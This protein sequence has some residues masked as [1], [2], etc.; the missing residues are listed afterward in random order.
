MRDLALLADDDVWKTHIDDDDWVRYIHPA[1]Y[2][3]FTILRAFSGLS[4]FASLCIVLESIADLK[5]ISSSTGNGQSRRRGVNGI[6]ATISRILLTMHS[7]VMI[8]MICFTLGMVMVPKNVPDNHSGGYKAHGNMATCTAQGFLLTLSS[9][10]IAAWDIA[11]C[12]TYILILMHN[13]TAQQ[14][15]HAEPYFFAFAAAISL[16]ISIPPLFNQSYN[17]RWGV[18]TLQSYKPFCHAYPEDP[19]WTCERGEDYIIYSAIHAAFISISALVGLI[20]MCKIYAKVRRLEVATARYDFS[21]TPTRQQRF[22]RRNQSNDTFASQQSPTGASRSTH[23]NRQSK[24]RQF[25]IQA[26]LYSGTAV[27]ASIFMISATV[28]NATAEGGDGYLSLITG[29]TYASYGT[30]YLMIFLRNRSE[31]KTLYGRMIRRLVC[32]VDVRRIFGKLPRSTKRSSSSNK[33][34]SSAG[35][36]S[37][38]VAPQSHRSGEFR[39]SAFHEPANSSR[40]SP[41]VQVQDDSFNDADADDVIPMEATIVMN[42]SSSSFYY[43]SDTIQ[44]AADSDILNSSDGQLDYYDERSRRPA[45]N[46]SKSDTDT[47]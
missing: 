25:A 46:G 47:L 12:A 13:W 43:G 42:S 21:A 26:L 17:Y 41:E 29:C 1:D 31:M 5:S 27:T 16:G 8:L 36:R 23:A 28:Y 44:T 14:L 20:T 19:N 38:S 22:F 33:E 15:R 3:Y 40:S 24:S 4:V 39:L 10:A 37:Q 7:F 34:S 32:C 45:S 2:G 30:I 6:N 9:T 11:L 18:C 35:N